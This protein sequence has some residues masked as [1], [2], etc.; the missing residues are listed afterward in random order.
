MSKAVHILRMLGSCEKREVSGRT[1]LGVKLGQPRRL[2][3]L[4]EVVEHPSEAK[5]RKGL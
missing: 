3:W 5:M 2:F 1:N 4:H